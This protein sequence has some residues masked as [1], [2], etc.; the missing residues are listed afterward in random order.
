MRHFRVLTRID[1]IKIETMLNTGHSVREIADFLGFHRSSIY[2]EIKRGKYEHLCSDYQT[3]IRYSSDLA[4]KDREYKKA[5]T[6]RNVKIGYDRELADF[7]EHLI[8]E[9]FPAHAGVIPQDE[10]MALCFNC[11]PRACGGDPVVRSELRKNRFHNFS[12]GEYDI[13]ELE[14]ILIKNY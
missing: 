11:V 10:Y 3:E 13:T 12:Q 4:Q 9:V 1:R 5:A 2:R 7:L 8:I 14:K 6:G